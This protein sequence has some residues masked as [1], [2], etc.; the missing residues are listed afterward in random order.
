[1][2]IRKIREKFTVGETGVGSFRYTGLNIRHCTNGITLDQLHYVRDMENI[3]L[4]PERKKEK[5]D[6]L[7][8]DELQSY[9][10]SVGVVNWASQ[11]TRPDASFEVMEMSMKFKDAHV[12]DMIR[13][14]KCI[15]KMKMNDVTIMF[16]KLSAPVRILS[17]SDAAFANLLDGVSSGAGHVIVLMDNDGH[18]CPLAWNTNKVKRVVKSTLAA[19]ALTLEEAIAHAMY[20]QAL[21]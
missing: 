17:W 8:R 13:V 12:N 16:R 20:L 6:N 5:L 9:R 3:D 18:C 2:I 21:L 19:E 11:Q 1:M 14:G 15:R 10:A 7:D 4:Q